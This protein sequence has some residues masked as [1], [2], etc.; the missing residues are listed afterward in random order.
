MC[1]GPA[2]A[3]P[4][5]TTPLF[6]ARTAG[7]QI[8]L[9]QHKII[10]LR[11]VAASA[12]KKPKRIGSRRSNSGRGLKT[13][14]SPLGLLFRSPLCRPLIGIWIATQYPDVGDSD[15]GENGNPG[16]PIYPSLQRLAALGSEP[17]GRCGSSLSGPRFGWA[18]QDC[19][20]CAAKHHS[21]GKTS[22]LAPD[23]DFGRS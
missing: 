11:K 22:W 23:R 19:Y 2:P 4:D 18:R 16:L 13:A 10:L 3:R 17:H 15:M 5:R 14:R 6:C 21:G 20:C 8:P 7:V 9:I 1:R 12:S